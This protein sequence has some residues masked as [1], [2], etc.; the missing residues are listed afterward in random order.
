MS[1]R[2]CGLLFAGLLSFT[3]ASAQPP[4]APQGGTPGGP[5]GG[6]GNGGAPRFSEEVGGTLPADRYSTSPTAIPICKDFGTRG[7]TAERSSKCRIIP[8][9]VRRSSGPAKARL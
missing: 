6:P 7:T 9:A 4:A 2:F 5:G 1:S 8:P 3:L